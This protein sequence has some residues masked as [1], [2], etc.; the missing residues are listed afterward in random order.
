MSASAGSVLDAASRAFVQQV[1]SIVAASSTRDRL[2]VAARATGCRVLD[3]GRLVVLLPGSRSERLRAAVRETACVAVVFS[4]PRNHR[5]IQ[6]KG[7][8]ARET[9]TEPVVDEKIALAYGKSF[10]ALLVELGYRNVMAQTL[11]QVDTPDL[12]AIVFTPV[13]LFDQ[14]PGPHAGQRVATAG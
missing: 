12:A 11:L 4:D 2:P 14:T 6:L 13:E 3:D 1:V 10:A 8:D 5:T 7:T 9:T